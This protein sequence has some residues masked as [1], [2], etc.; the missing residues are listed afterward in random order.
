MTSR[1][2]RSAAVTAV[3]AILSAA[4]LVAATENVTPMEDPLASC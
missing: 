3:L 1:L 2:I 4:S